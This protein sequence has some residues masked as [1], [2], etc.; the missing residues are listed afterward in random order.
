M[1]EVKVPVYMFHGTEDETVPYDSSVR[2]EK[3]SENIVL[4]TIQ[5]GSHNNL[6]TFHEY[7]ERLDDILGTN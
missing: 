3:L 1:P 4:Y 5:D 2:L 6:N 7:H